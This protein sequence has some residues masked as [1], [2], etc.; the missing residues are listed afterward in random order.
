MSIAVYNMEQPS[1]SLTVSR[2][3]ASAHMARRTDLGLQRHVKFLQMGGHAKYPELWARRRDHQRQS[4]TPSGVYWEW[5]KRMPQLKGKISNILI[6]SVY[7][8]KSS[9]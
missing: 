9:S 1:S 3:Y 5:L 2:M 6:G 4:L 7:A 8:I